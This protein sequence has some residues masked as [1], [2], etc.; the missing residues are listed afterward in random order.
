MFRFL[1][2]SIIVPYSVVAQLESFLSFSSFNSTEGPYLESYLSVN[3]N[4]IKL[5]KNSEN[6]YSGKVSVSID[7]FS[8][9]DT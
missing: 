2:I 3:S 1:L 8:S 5:I 7:V 4:T 9:H 6:F